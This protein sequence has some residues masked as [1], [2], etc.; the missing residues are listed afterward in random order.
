MAD[1]KDF[2][3]KHRTEWKEFLWDALAEKIASAKSKRQARQILDRLFSDYEKDLAAKRIAALS[4]IHQGLGYKEI[5]EI[6]WLSHPTISAIKKNFFGNKGVYKSQRSFRSV[7]KSES[8][9]HIKF[10]KTSPL[11]DLLNKIDIWE[12]IKNPPRPTGTGI[13]G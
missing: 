1:Y 9:I 6:L 12:L 7:N 11:I 4:L 10:T 13:K 8:S 3:N 5:S 2:K